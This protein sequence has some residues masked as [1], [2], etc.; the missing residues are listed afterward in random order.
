MK[1]ETD[2][3][4]PAKSLVESDRLLREVYAHLEEKRYAHPDAPGHSHFKRGR[5]DKDGS[6]CAWCKVWD[7]VR[8]YVNATDSGRC[9]GGVE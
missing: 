7:D 3:G 5:W 8:A 6:E 9:V 1:T 4:N 2:K